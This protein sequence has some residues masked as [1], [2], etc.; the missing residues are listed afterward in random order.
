MNICEEHDDCIVIFE[1][2]N[3]TICPV[4]SEIEYLQEQADIMESQE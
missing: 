4:C 3:S 1:T 2:N